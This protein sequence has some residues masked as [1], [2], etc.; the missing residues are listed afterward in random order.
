M[1]R[2]KLIVATVILI[3]TLVYAT[4]CG[5]DHIEAHFGI[6]MTLFLVLLDAS[7]DRTSG[8]VPVLSACEN[9]TQTRVV[10]YFAV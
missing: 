1:A 3:G 10:V 9:L 4:E 8:N 7:C 6:L 5:S 2:V